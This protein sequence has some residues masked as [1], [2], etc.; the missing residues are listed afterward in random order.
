MLEVRGI[1]KRY[2]S[3]QALSDVSLQFEAGEIHSLLGENGAGKSTLVRI[4]TGN[5]EADAGE[6]LIDGT[7]TQLSSPAV[8][9]ELGIAAV[10]QELSLIPN[11]TVSQNLSIEQVPT[12]GGP[13]GRLTGVVDNRELKRRTREIANRFREDWDPNALVSSLTPS[14]RQRLEIGRAL[15][16]NAKML[17]LDEPTSSLAPDD[18]DELYRK[19]RSLRDQGIAIVFITHNLEEAL[20]VSDR[21]SVLRDGRHVGTHQCSDLTVDRVV[22]LMTGRRAGSL[23]PKREI[24]APKAHPRLSVRHLSAAP[25]LKDVSFDLYPGEI[26]GLAGLVGSGRTKILRAIFGT[27][28]LTNGSIQLDGARLNVSSPGEAIAN[29]VALIP[30]DRQAEGL[31]PSHTVTHN[32]TVVAATTTGR[33]RSVFISPKRLQKLASDMIARLD[34]KVGSPLDPASKLSGGNQQKLVLARWLAI[35][36]KVLLADEP[37]RGVSIGSKVEIYRTLRGQARAGV[38]IVV[39]SSEFDELIGLCDRIILVRDGRTVGES[40]SDDLSEDDLLNMLLSQGR[41][42]VGEREG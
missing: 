28:N 22:E 23:F 11:L 27:L 17:V 37:T 33:V 31:F 12:S 7:T 36:P 6:I 34:I 21:V 3:T 38:G 1:S 32:I 35:Q 20:E 10:H 2:G 14:Q 13:L 40:S 9:N 39:V 16:R 26:L 25:Y 4:I 29:G 15:S 24:A 42:V 19:L 5:T 41:S 18:R 30:E 8:A